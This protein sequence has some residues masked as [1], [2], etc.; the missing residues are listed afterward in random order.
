MP[1]IQVAFDFTAPREAVAL[2]AR[3]GHL[4][5]WLEIGTPMIKTHGMIAITSMRRAFP[6]K[7]ILADLKTMDAGGLETALAMDAGADTVTVMGVACDRT[8]A[9]AVAEASRRGGHVSVDLMRVQDK[10]K[11]AHEVKALGAAYI[12]DHVGADERAMGTQPFA[13]LATF[14]SQLPL[15]LIIAG[16]VN[17]D[18]ID[19]VMGFS[20]AVVVLGTDVTQAP[21]P[22]HAL[23]AIMDRAGILPAER[24]D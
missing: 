7:T 18:T 10:P 17:L 8:I 5:D 2:A 24:E 11:R 9:D 6:G 3:L 14:R 22:A 15:P 20:P 12:E 4:V 1:K 23:M 19:C 21:D 16:G 13:E